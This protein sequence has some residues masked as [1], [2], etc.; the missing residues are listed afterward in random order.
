MTGRKISPLS[1]L[2]PKRVINNYMNMSHVI[3]LSMV[4]SSAEDRGKGND[5]RM[6]V[7]TC[8]LGFLLIAFTDKGV[9]AIE[10]GDDST[11]LTSQFK[12]RYK[13]T[14][15]PPLTAEDRNW[16]DLIL[17]KMENPSLKV[18]IPLDIG[19]TDFQRKVWDA[20][21]QIP[22]GETRTYSDIAQE[23]GRPKSVRAVANACGKNKIAL[24]IPC[25]RVIGKNGTLRGYRW[26]VDK[27]NALLKK[28]EETI[29]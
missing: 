1:V 2:Y 25:H 28:E 18:T 14:F 29:K 10:I 8:F 16:V 26:G 6:D 17:K 20:L 22:P 27:K 9:I 5:I 7:Y 11:E 3:I 23:I 21:Q 19:G 12:E 4:P 13:Y 24:L 15:I